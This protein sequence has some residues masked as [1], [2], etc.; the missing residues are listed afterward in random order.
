[1]S[2]DGT[3]M[4]VDVNHLVALRNVTGKQTYPREAEQ[5]DHFELPVSGEDF[6]N[7]VHQGQRG[8]CGLQS[9]TSS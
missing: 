8:R 9:G 6:R 5:I 7:W 3:L 2:P 1:M 4:D